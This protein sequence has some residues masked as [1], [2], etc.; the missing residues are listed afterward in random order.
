ME[1]KKQLVRA[2]IAS[3]DAIWKVD[4]DVRFIQ[5]D[6]I[7]R[8]I[9]M[10]PASSQAKKMAAGFIGDK[11][12]AWDMLSGRIFPELGGHPKY[13]DI[14]GANYYYYNQE[15]ILPKRSPNGSI[16]MT[17]PWK[18]KD[19]ASLVQMLAEVYERYQRPMVVAETG[20]WGAL[21]RMWWPRTLREL[22]S[23]LVRKLPIYGACAYP[24]IDRP[25]WTYGHLTN[26]GLW[27]FKL[28]DPKSTRIPHA[29]S[30]RIV[31]KF[32]KDLRK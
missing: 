9:P 8:R 31:K 6:P 10:E 32:I 14:L 7:F 5:V 1:F 27:D 2:T 13:L 26:S 22:N 4:R 23:A 3:M 15:Y 16:Y 29:P 25:D 28:N 19:R 12:Q 21:R 18:S 20:G 30:I 24:I 11:F 17:I